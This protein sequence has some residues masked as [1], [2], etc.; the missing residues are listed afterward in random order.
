MNLFFLKVFSFLIGLFITLFIINYINI[1]NKKRENFE[2]KKLTKDTLVTN[3]SNNTNSIQEIPYKNFKYMCI[4]SFFDIK[5][6]GNTEGKWYDIDIDNKNNY[7]TFSKMINL[8]NNKIN[9]DGAKGAHLNGIELQGLKSFYYANNINSN[10]LTE[11]SIIMSLR[12]NEIKEKNNIIFEMIGNTEE[13]INKNNINYTYSIININIQQ[14]TN[15]NYNFI[16]T[17][18]NYVYSGNINNI[19]KTII[20]NSDLLIIGLIYTETEITFLINK[21]M[22]KYKTNKEFTI[23]LGSMPLIINKYGNINMELYNFTYYKSIIPINEYLKFFKHN[24]HYLAGINKILNLSSEE[25]KAAKK[26]ASNNAK[27]CIQETKETTSININK[28]IDSLE[29]SLGKCFDKNN[30][31]KKIDEIK[32]FELKLMDNIKQTSSNFFN[33]LFE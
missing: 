29:K 2:I 21:E 7:F 1:E 22:Y 28:R 19:N 15:D 30:I 33:F 8:K 25:L 9:I 23:K 3:N 6:I 16:L 18:G 27:K 24:Y 32:P 12:I 31:K 4:S 5:Q 10:E 20:R 11:F 13:I 14:N 17:I 26:D